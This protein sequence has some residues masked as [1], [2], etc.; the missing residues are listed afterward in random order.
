MGRV[1]EVQR[2]GVVVVAHLKGRYQCTVGARE[3]FASSGQRDL[4]D[5]GGPARLIQQQV[6]VDV[7]LS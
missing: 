4:V 7:H 3:P 6:D 2:V 5:R 1:V